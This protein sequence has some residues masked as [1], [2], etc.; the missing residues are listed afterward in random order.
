MDYSTR[1]LPMSHIDINTVLVASAAMAA[2]MS[3]LF[4]MML[5]ARESKYDLEKRRI[6]IDMMRASL[7]RKVYEANDQLV[8]A[9]SRWKDVNHLLLEA[10]RRLEED[11]SSAIK[12]GSPRIVGRFLRTMGVRPADFESR[13]NSAFV[14]TPF[15]DRHAK[16]YETIVRV[17]NRVGIEC[18]RGDEE[19]IEGGVLR[20]IAKA[21]ASAG[22]VIANIDG[23]NPNVFYELGIAHAM[24]KE[25]LLVASAKDEIPFDFR[26]QR[27]LIYKSLPELEERMM[28]ALAQIRRKEG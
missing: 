1:L 3:L 23:R 27:I 17:C 2:L 25:V 10:A 14:L 22:I 20:H 7:E 15:H 5:R 18:Q 13:P 24:D 6:E 12:S 4:H 19:Y 16:T 8:A 28:T 21:I 9:P 26:N 11:G